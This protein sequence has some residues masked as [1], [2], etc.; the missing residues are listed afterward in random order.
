MHRLTKLPDGLRL[1]PEQVRSRNQKEAR[2]HLLSLTSRAAL[3]D[4]TSTVT[5]FDAHRSGK[6]LADI[7]YQCLEVCCV[8][9][10]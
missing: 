6:R 10:Q 9:D 1:Q 2:L 5:G 7:F 4:A 3:Q 8:S